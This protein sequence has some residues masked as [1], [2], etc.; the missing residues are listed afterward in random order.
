MYGPVTNGV[1]E[2]QVSMATADSCD[3][4][5]TAIYT[6]GQP[7]ADGSRRCDT[8]T[9]VAIAILSLPQYVTAPRGS[10]SGNDGD[11]WPQTGSTVSGT[12]AR[13]GH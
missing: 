4:S 6:V 13:E 1:G 11:D 8:P 5:P 10:G 2:C 7:A 12:P 9:S 3:L